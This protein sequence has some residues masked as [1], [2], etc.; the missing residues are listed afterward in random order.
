MGVKRL[1]VNG[2]IIGNLHQAR[3]DARVSAIS[4]S[5]ADTRSE[6]IP[7]PGWCRPIR[8]S[9]AARQQRMK[10]SAFAV[11]VFDVRPDA[12]KRGPLDSK[13]GAAGRRGGIA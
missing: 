9:T 6:A 13:P 12:F 8:M 10:A 5:M 11:D 3:A 1:R 7:V 2:G 4:V